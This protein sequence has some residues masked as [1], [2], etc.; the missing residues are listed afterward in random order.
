MKGN[1][2]KTGS[3]PKI[4][5]IVLC[6]HGCVGNLFKVGWGLIMVS[7]MAIHHSLLKITFLE[8]L[9]GLAYSLTRAAS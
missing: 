7:E 8:S 1:E 9:R 5:V 6:V 4:I 2:N 3:P